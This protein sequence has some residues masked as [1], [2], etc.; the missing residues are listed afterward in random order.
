MGTLKADRD[1]LDEAAA[2]FYGIAAELTK[3]CESIRRGEGRG[4]EFGWF[5]SRAGIDSA[6][7]T[8]I[9]DMITALE[10]GAQRQTQIGDII[11]GIAQDF[12]DTD[13]EQA[14]R[15][16]NPDGTPA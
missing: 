7:D 10:A 2:G 6:H 16:H 11:R 4:S 8:F 3:A 14:D 9:A 13:A 15:Y 1:A 5:A 12:G